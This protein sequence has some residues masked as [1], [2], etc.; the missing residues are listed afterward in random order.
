M[1]SGLR[2]LLIAQ[3]VLTLAAAL[4]MYYWRAPTTGIVLAALYGGGIAL[5]DS[6]LL[7]WRT[8]RAAERASAGEG[9]LQVIS[10]LGGAVERFVFTLAAFGLGM[11]VLELD[12]VAL[13]AGFA[14]A[15][16]GYL[17]AAYRP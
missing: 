13:I 5:V 9:Q 1:R 10:L 11:A 4:L 15:E 7:A 12:P 14:C 17:G 6:L 2:R 16:M 3:V 8:R